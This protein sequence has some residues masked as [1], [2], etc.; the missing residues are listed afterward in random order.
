MSNMQKIHE[1]AQLLEINIS[2]DLLAIFFDILDENVSV[3]DFVLMYDEIRNE[4]E[5]ETI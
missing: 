5:N 2:Q 4:Y 1:L 3:E